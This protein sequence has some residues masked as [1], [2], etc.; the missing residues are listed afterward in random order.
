MAGVSFSS[1]ASQFCC[2]FAA[3][4]DH[5]G[6]WCD[7]SRDDDAWSAAFAPC[8]CCVSVNVLPHVQVLGIHIRGALVLSCALM[9]IDLLRKRG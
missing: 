5:K 6:G 4:G 8:M 7:V 2:F 3:D 1:F 9:G